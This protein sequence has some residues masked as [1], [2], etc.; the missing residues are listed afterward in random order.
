MDYR[1]Q[2]VAPTAKVTMTLLSPGDEKPH[3]LEIQTKISKTSSL[4]SVQE[5]FDRGTVRHGWFDREKINEFEQFGND[6][7]IWKNAHLL[8]AGFVY[9]PG[10]G[11]NEKIQDAH[12]GPT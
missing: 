2:T 5:L 9:R 11:K 3:V 12:P 4:V 6:L 1:Y 8:A 10:D 7:T